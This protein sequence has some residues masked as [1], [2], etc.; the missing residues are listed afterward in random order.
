MTNKNLKR[1]LEPMINDSSMVRETWKIFQVVSEIVE[2]YER[3]THITPS[4]S[5]YGSARTSIDDPLYRDAEILGQEL[6]RAGF[7][8]VTGGA[9]GIMEA[10]NKGAFEGGSPSIGLNIFLEHEKKPNNYQ[11]ISLRF[12]HFFTRKLMFVKYAFA[13]VIFPGGYGTLD[14]LGELLVL[15][16]KN[17]GNKHLIVLY[18]SEY[19]QEILAWFTN[20]ALARGMISQQDLDLF[21]V[22]D[23]PEEVVSIIQSAYKR[24]A[25][26]AR[27]ADIALQT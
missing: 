21:C 8:V 9:S 7:S 16:Q 10:A 6:S 15:M 2:G 27:T 3:L 24:S 26:K 13:H 19:W 18:D 11:D 17:K 14:E 4:V 22:V 5:I 1:P 25:P 12:R 20:K 23:K